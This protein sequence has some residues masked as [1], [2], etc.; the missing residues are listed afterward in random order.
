MSF[1]D[2]LLGKRGSK[3]EPTLPERATAPQPSQKADPLEIG[4]GTHIGRTREANEDTFLT[5]KSVIGD[6]ADPLAVAL[7]IVADGMGGHMKGQEA[8]SLAIRVAGEVIVR[9]ALLPVLSRRASEIAIRPIH[10]ILTEAAVSA[11]QAVGE[12]ESDAGTTLTCALV[13]GHSAYVAHVGDTRVY[14]LDDDGLQ[15]ITQDH[16]LVNRLTELGQISAQEAQHH[17]QRNFLY[18]A[19]GQGHDLKVDTY[20]R[21]LETGSHLILCSDGL[22]SA[23]SDEEIVDVIG[24]SCCPQEACNELIARA[25]DHGGEDNITMILAKINY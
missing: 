14:Y 19:L 5:L 13:L 4:Q 8:S 15:Q 21:R 7:L 17:P 9:E 20:S 25:N 12:M 1:W 22:W 16:S 2:K 11:N 6:E 18:R 3:R 23:V 24:I 10:E